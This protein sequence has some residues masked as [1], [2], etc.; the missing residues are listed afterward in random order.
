MSLQYIYRPA[1]V[2]SSGKSPVLLL[3]HGVGSNEQSLLSLTEGLD[4]RFAV[5]SLR[6]PLVLGA[7][8]FAWFHVN[9]TAQ[10][11]LHNQ[12]EA[13]QSRKILIDFIRALPKE[14]P[15]IDAENIFVLGFS[16]GTIMGLSLA[17]TEPDL[18][19]GLVAISGRTLQEVSAQAKERTY[20]RSPKVLLMHGRQDSKLP[21][22]HGLNTEAVL[23]AASFDF[24][25]ESYEADHHIT[26]QMLQ[27][28][29]QWL[30][31]R[32]SA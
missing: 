14:N 26:P 30:I 20:P 10:G 8:S 4:P 1:K 27:D 32:I 25:F 13:E 29:H 16:Q 6:A 12:Q 31:K 28:L 3:L 15:D 24:Q 17:L 18:F 7:G 22:T 21:Y 11:P 2:K 23:K 5:Y 19:K 9:F